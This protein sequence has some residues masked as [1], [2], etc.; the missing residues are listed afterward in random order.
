MGGGNAG[1]TGVITAGVVVL[2]RGVA[3]GFCR[4]GGMM[5]VAVVVDLIRLMVVALVSS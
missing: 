2:R 5:L 4:H 3:G 1:C